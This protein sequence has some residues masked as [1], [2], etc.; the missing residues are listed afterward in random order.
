MGIQWTL[1]SFLAQKKGIYRVIQLRKLIAEETGILISFSNLS[2]YVEDKPK[3]LPLPTLEIICSALKCK[4][5]DFCEVTP[6]SIRPS[7][8]KEVRKLSYHN[9][10]HS[11]R[12]VLAFPEP[13]D[14]EK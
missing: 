7:E 6:K 11:K 4:L 13:K 1:K 14:Y 12:A 5:S 8:L 10:P 2:T 9:T 3:N